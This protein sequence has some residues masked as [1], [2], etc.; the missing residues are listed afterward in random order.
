MTKEKKK[1]VD[2]LRRKKTREVLNCC[3]KFVFTLRRFFHPLLD[4][5]L[6]ASM[7]AR[8]EAQLPV[9]SWGDVRSEVHNI[10]L[11]VAIHL[12]ERTFCPSTIC[13]TTP[14]ELFWGYS[15]KTKFPMK[16]CLKLQD[17]HFSHNFPAALPLLSIPA[18]VA[19]VCAAGFVG[20]PKDFPMASSPEKERKE[21]TTQ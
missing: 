1:K 9:F 12:G 14:W 15:I 2:S 10:S 6:E 20:F 3:G 17:F 21:K 19:T 13:A 16:E 5:L 4:S 7:L 18:K 11:C 8:S